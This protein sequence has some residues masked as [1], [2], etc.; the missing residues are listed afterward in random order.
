MTAGPVPGAP[1]EPD[2]RSGPQGRALELSRQ[3]ARDGLR[4]AAITI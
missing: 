2:L 3:S 1:A 4:A